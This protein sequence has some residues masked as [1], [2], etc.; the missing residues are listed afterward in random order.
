MLRLRSTT[1]QVAAEYM[2]VLLMVAAIVTALLGS[3]L[4]THIA[5]EAQ[6]AVCKITG[7]TPGG[8]AR[9]PEGRGPFGRDSY[10]NSAAELIASINFCE[11]CG[12]PTH[13]ASWDG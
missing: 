13:N 1:G 7:S 4:H 10:D 9:R 6:R 12:T 2:G 3:Q 5:V 8:R 11:D